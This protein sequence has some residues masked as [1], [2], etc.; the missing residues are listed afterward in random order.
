VFEGSGFDVFLVAA[1]D[2]AGVAVG[3]EVLEVRGDGGVV[4][5]DGCV[6]G[7]V[8][9]C[10]VWGEGLGDGAEAVVWW[11]CQSCVILD[12]L[13]EKIIWIWACVCHWESG[14]NV[15][16]QGEDAGSNISNDSFCDC[17][18][19]GSVSYIF[20]EDAVISLDALIMRSRRSWCSSSS[21]RKPSN[22][23]MNGDWFAV[24]SWSSMAA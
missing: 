16:L 3:V 10:D 17:L 14:E 8:G 20:F 23:G 5:R 18:M 6:E 2:L 21:A 1:G 12:F 22:M 24:L 15:P 19:R 13:F 7:G 9:F 11:W 4:C